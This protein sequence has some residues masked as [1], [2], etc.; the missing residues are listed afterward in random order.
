MLILSSICALGVVALL[1]LSQ[2]E[3][4]FEGRYLSD[5]IWTMNGAQAGPEK[6]KA[7]VVVRQLGSNSIPLLL[8]W[9]RREDRPSLT[10]RVD[11]L[12]HAIFYWLIRHKVIANRPIRSLRDFNPSHSAMAMWALPELDHSGRTVVI[13]TLIKMLGE[14]SRKPDQMPRAV[15]GAFMVL[16]KM[17]PEST[18]PLIEALS[19]HDP[20]VWALAA[21]ALGEIGPDAKAAI[22]ILEQSLKDKDPLIRV[23]AAGVIGKI[24][25]DPNLFLP[26]VIQSLTEIDW[27]RMDCALDILVL[28]KEHAKA[29]VPVLVGIL[30]NTP[31]SSNPTNTIIR[32]QVIN[33]LRQI[34]PEALPKT[35]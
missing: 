30:D 8:K 5:W 4:S 13:P 22:P 35:R 21:A 14:K 26:V 20:Q 7:R 3:P 16:S 17:A 9:L 31:N 24:G 19:S 34:D 6:E 15:G 29:A 11:D 23:G 2:R 28:Y 27:T 12:R 25:G 32:D 18:A 10:N 1:A 33:A